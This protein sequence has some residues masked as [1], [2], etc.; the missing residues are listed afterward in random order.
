MLIA[1]V[2]RNARA[3]KLQWSDPTVHSSTVYSTVNTLFCAHSSKFDVEVSSYKYHSYTRSD[4]LLQYAFFYARVSYLL[5]Q[6]IVITNITFIWF[7]SS[8]CFFYAVLNG[9]FEKIFSYKHRIHKVS[10]PYG[11]FDV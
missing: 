2:M 3:H 1:C 5:L 10:L 7:L 9:I 8:V 11:F 4:L 6:E